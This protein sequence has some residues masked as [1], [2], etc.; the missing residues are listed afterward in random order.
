MSATQ[1]GVCKK[2]EDFLHNCPSNSLKKLG[3]AFS[4]IRQ[5][6]LSENL[7]QYKNAATDYEAQKAL[8]TTEDRATFNTWAKGMR[9]DLGI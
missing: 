2:I 4:A 6:I 7:D 5:A 3:L 9:Y 8:L 1:E